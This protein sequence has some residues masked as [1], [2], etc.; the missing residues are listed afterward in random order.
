MATTLELFSPFQRLPVEPRCLIWH[1]CLPGPRL[2]PIHYEH[3]LRRYSTHIPRP[4]VLRIDRE[5]RH[6]GLRVYHQIRLGL[7]ENIGCYVDPLRD[8]VYLISN[9]KN[10]HNMDEL[11]YFLYEDL[12][13][14]PDFEALF[15]NLT[16]SARTWRRLFHSV[17][18]RRFKQF[19]NLRSVR[20]VYEKGS[21]PVHESMELQE[22]EPLAAGED[23]PMVRWENSPF[24]S[25]PSQYSVGY[26]FLIHD[27]DNIWQWIKNDKN[28]KDLLK[29]R[30]AIFNF[31]I[32]RCYI[33]KG[34]RDGN[35]YR[36]T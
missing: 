27:D 1:F 22:F 11:V 8:T 36:P 2:V 9:F 5:S 14:S 25:G 15:S 33:D 17:C 16:I 24:P 34:G 20:P 6:E 30:S 31:E 28:V 29:G 3:N 23:D 4:V 18:E 26:Q 21:G 10:H 12:Y 32:T 35:V 13:T 19:L 7:N